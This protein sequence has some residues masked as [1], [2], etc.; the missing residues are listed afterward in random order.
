[1][2]IKNFFYLLIIAFIV[3]CSPATQSNEDAA[4]DGYKML[5]MGNSFLDH[6]QT[7]LTLSLLKL[8]LMSTLVL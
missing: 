1:M 8:I 6:M 2:N 3:S 4:P 5:L 7:I